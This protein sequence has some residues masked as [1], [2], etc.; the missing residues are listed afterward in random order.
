VI[1]SRLC[2]AA[3]VALDGEGARLWGG[4]WNTP[5]RPMV[6]TAA[7]P[8]LAV[9]EVLV[10]LDLPSALL[11]DDYMLLTIDVPEGAPVRRIETGPS[12]DADCRRAGDAFLAAGAA[13]ALMV[14]SAVVPQERNVLLNPRHPAM[15]GTAIVRTEPFR[16]DPRLLA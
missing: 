15:Q 2:K 1:V 6:Y 13:L 16:F 7:S 10:H 9:L 4:R 5:G 11:P 3:H 14:R 12:A 8:S